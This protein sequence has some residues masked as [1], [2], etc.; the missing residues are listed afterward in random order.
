MLALYESDFLVLRIVS[1]IR[2]CPLFGVSFN[3]DSTVVD[4]FLWFFSLLASVARVDGRGRHY[5]EEIKPHPAQ[6]SSSQG[7]LQGGSSC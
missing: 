2:R 7:Q 1:F 3:G 6:V 4:F 5:E